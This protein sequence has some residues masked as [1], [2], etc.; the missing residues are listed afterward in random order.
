[1]DYRQTFRQRFKQFSKF[2]NLINYGLLPAVNNERAGMR[3]V[4]RTHFTTERSDRS[5]V[6]G[7][8]VIRPRR[9]VEMFHLSGIIV[10][11]NLERPDHKV[12]CLFHVGQSDTDVAVLLLFALSL[13]PVH[14]TLPLNTSDNYLAPW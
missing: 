12:R 2:I 4:I 1:M 11:A 3:L 7:D 14:L 13:R 5:G 10:A 6:V 9:V 8:S